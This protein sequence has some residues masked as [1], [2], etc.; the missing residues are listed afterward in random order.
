MKVLL[1]STDSQIFNEASP[2]RARILEYGK[3]FEELCV[4][5]YTRPGKIKEEIGNVSILPTNNRFRMGYFARAI[6]L[7]RKVMGDGGGWVVSSQD[8]FETGWVAYRLK[9]TLRIPFQVQIHTDFMSS[10]FGRAS[11]KNRL[12]VVIAKKIVRK[13][14]RIRV[15]SERIKKSLVVLDAKLESKIAVLPIFVDK[16]TFR[17]ASPV[18]RDALKI[19][20][21]DFLILTVARK[22]P[23]KNMALANDIIGE[24]KKRGNRVKWFHFGY[25]R[26]DVGAEWLDEALD[27]QDLKARYYKAADLFLL[28]SNYEGYGM[29]AVEAAAA[30]VPVV[31]TDVGVAL[32]AIFPVGDKEKAVAIIEELI[33]SPE[34]RKKLVEQ[35]NEFFK[36]WPTKEQ[37]F[38]QFKKSLT[39]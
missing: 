6:R 38:D 9:K 26:N 19:A 35:Q 31:M 30:V 22:G 3:L 13:A 29:V 37:Y 39:F 1:L 28:T 14:D 32:G 2:A 21:E 20:R 33:R 27:N 8:P 4:V 11:L 34:K 25:G 10:Y 16:E 12:R 17:L 15:V 36:N 7:G 24:L 18:S 5:V 23:E